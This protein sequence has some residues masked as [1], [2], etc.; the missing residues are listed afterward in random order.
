MI[1]GKDNSE[2]DV[3]ADC[4][5]HGF[6]TN[7]SVSTFTVTNARSYLAAYSY[8]LASVRTL[9]FGADC[10]TASGTYVNEDGSNGVETLVRD[11]PVKDLDRK[12]V[13]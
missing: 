2:S 9:T 13:V 7:T 11:D 4:Y 5:H 3:H 6:V 1:I 12:S 10:N 8:C